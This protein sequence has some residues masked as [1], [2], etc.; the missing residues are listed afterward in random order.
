MADGLPRPIVRDLKAL[1]HTGTAC[2]LSDRQL[3]ERFAAGRDPSSEAAFEVLVLRHGP[4]VLRVCHRILRERA[5]AEDAFQ[6]TFLVLVRRR[7]SIRRLE[8]V[9]GW[10][11]GVACRV[12]AHARLE[13]ARRRATEERAA[14]RNFEAVD[15]VDGAGRD[16]AE[17]VSVI[18]DEVRWLPERYR[19]AVVLCYLQGL[20]LK[21]AAAQL[22]CP[23]GT[24]R[25]RLARARKLLHSR[26]TRRGMAPLVGVVA[27]AFDSALA[28]SIRLPPVPGALASNTAKAAARFAAGRAT[29]EVT[30]TT[31]AA[32]VQ[33][34]LRSMLIM[35]LKTIGVGVVLIGVGAFGASLAAPQAD[36][37]KL[38]PA[39]RRGPRPTAE[40]SKS[41]AQP[42]LVDHGSYVV[43]PPDL[44]IVEVLEALPGR[45]ISGE[46]LV[47]PDGKISLGFYGDVYVAGLTVPE[48][49]EKVIRHLQKYIGDDKLGLIARDRTTLEPIVDLESGKPKSIDP[50]ESDAVFVQVTAYNS[51]FYYVL[52]EVVVPG[53]LPVKGKETVLDAVN[54]V[55]GLRPQA[56]HNNVVL[57]RH[58]PD[59]ALRAMQVD[60]DQIM[61]GDDLS[62]NYQLLPVDRL[63]IPQNPRFKPDA[64][65]TEANQQIPVSPRRSNG[66]IPPDRRSERSDRS[67][68]LPG[69]ADRLDD[70][71]ALLDVEKR[72]SEVERKL[73]LILEALKPRTP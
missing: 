72:L 9:R 36:S 19:A 54:L 10:L 41:K 30:S 69:R 70:R 63:V 45:P 21:Q 18:Q 28:G 65:E 34:F 35:K 31:V 3:L 8:S 60:I 16:R 67:V 51:K 39:A 57:Y 53:R 14:V 66:A 17:L 11:H 61:M 68:E 26:L 38:A 59:G 24:V 62:T 32:L 73:D 5:D 7:R 27:A 48:I 2:G 15:P 20:T 50:R 37:A 40:T 22:G 47:R 42:R 64:A 43:E 46:R 58:A 6:A 71:A 12:A 13:A 33:Q 55:G 29:T 4:M 1:F 23:L 56:D 52:G 25:S 49:K 44:L